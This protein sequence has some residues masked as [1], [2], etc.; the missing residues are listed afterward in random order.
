MLQ[1]EYLKEVKNR[2]PIKKLP[3]GRQDC[4]QAYGS[5]VNNIASPISRL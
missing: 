5:S 3:S 1:K 4:L 2:L